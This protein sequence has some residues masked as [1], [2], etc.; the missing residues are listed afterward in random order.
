MLQDINGN[1]NVLAA[2]HLYLGHLRLLTLVRSTGSFSRLGL[3][4]ERGEGLR[5][6]SRGQRD[7]GDWLVFVFLVLELLIFLFKLLLTFVQVLFLVFPVLKLLFVFV[8]FVVGQGNLSIRAEDRIRHFGRNHCPGRFAGLWMRLRRLR[9][10]HAQ[11]C[12]HDSLAPA[13]ANQPPAWLLQYGDIYFIAAFPQ[14]HQCL[15]DCLLD[16]LAAGFY[17]FHDDLASLSLHMLSGVAMLI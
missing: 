10:W 2:R 15:L 8:E 6:R 3:G 11:R 17:T 7:K 4:H 16:T 1:L 5:G 9:L 13:Q 14:A 12:A